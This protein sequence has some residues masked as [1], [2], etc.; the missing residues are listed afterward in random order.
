MSK[1]LLASMLFFTLILGMAACDT[2]T[3]NGATSQPKMSDSDLKTAIKTKIDTDAS[4]KAADLDV[5]A[6]ANTNTATLSGTVT[7]QELRTR[8]VDLARA[9]HSGLIITDK[10][11]VK[12]R[13]VSRSEY[14]E[15]QA[16]QERESARNSGEKL[17]DSLDDAWIH[18]KIVTKLI[19]NT[20]TPERKIN[21]DVVNN[22]VTLRGTVDTAEQKA[23]AERVAKETEGVKNVKNLLK[24]K[25]A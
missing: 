2:A 8:A 5:D 24:V 15:D 20:N 11:D 13:E 23:E 19:G 1:V 12:P 18:T 21:I 7:S 25:P 14:T 10:I 4:L 3:D 22:N 9:A 6:D 16:A 17:G